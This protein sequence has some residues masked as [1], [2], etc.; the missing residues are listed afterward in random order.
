[1]LQAAPQQDVEGATGTPPG[2]LPGDAERT[3]SPPPRHW[4]VPS[5][6]PGPA[7]LFGWLTWLVVAFGTVL[8]IR[9][10]LPGRSFWLD[11]LLLL[12]AMSEQPLWKV[13]RPLTLNQSAP[14]G[15]LFVEHL[16]L[17]VYPGERGARLLPLLFGIG[18]VVLT[19]LLARTLLGPVAAL[20]ATAVVAVSPAL[21][22]YSVELKP[23]SAD[24]FWLLLVLLLA[25]RVVL[26]RGPFLRGAVTLGAVATVAVCSSHVAA[27]GTAGMFVALG[28]V[29]L[30]G[31]RWREL[32]V[33]AACAA[34][35]AVLLAVEYVTLLSK[36]AA[37]PVLAAYWRP[38]FPP[39]GPLRWSVG[40]HWLAG[41]I[42]GLVRNPLYWRPS[43]ALLVLALAGLVVLGV[44]K[45]RA[46]P[47]VLMAAG[48]V[49]A[50][51][52]FRVYP[53]SVRLA[54]WMIPLVAIV[55][56]APLDLLLVGTERWRLPRL[57]AVAW[58]GSVAVAALL[59][60]AAAGQLVTV[61]RP[62]VR[63]D[64]HYLAEPRQQ[65][66]SRPA[67]QIIARDRRPG[68]LV[69]V[70]ARGSV[71]AAEYYGPRLGLGGYELIRKLPPTPD[72][73]RVR[74]GAMLR[75]DRSVRRIWLFYS[76]T[77]PPTVVQLAANLAGFGPLTFRRAFVIAGVLRFDRSAAPP[78]PSARAP[79]YCARIEPA[80]GG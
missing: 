22:Q 58:Y 35:A 23:Y 29:T 5:W 2:T 14:P 21:V 53:L 7:E 34:P 12:R 70:E 40:S 71:P 11:E 24:G 61:V 10:W 68:D 54:V 15:W 45:P 6:P 39:P 42:V 31:R 59:A 60:L 50:A 78:D 8:R 77:G 52:L 75:A 26:R 25:V 30:A 18:T 28:L 1:V 51:A 19:A 9:Q 73:P 41:R 76:H 69:L 36:N 66:E 63:L 43:Q 27:I 49:T 44:R 16:I 55:V 62:N 65:E 72:C 20:A 38:S 33:L 47:V 57:P 13:L 74:P 32:P 3:G 67:L 46:L 37:N 17:D 56:A 64:L 80:T 4:W 79:H 48:A